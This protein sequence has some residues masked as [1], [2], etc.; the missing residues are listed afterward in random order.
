MIPRQSQTPVAAARSTGSGMLYQWR[1]FG[2]PHRVYR[3]GLV[4]ADVAEYFYRDSLTRVSTSKKRDCYLSPNDGKIK[5]LVVSATYDMIEQAGAVTWKRTKVRNVVPWM[6][7]IALWP[8]N[9]TALEVEHWSSDEWLW[10][11][12]K[13]IPACL[14]LSFAVSLAHAIC[15]LKLISVLD[16]GTW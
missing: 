8:F 15:Y 14:C 12:L 11:T 6:Y 5:T 3:S 4:Y 16:S 10:V 9:H 13:W 2:N 1:F 7:R